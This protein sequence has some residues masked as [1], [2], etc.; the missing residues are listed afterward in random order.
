MALEAQ[1]IEIP[2]SGGLDTKS[3]EKLVIPGKLV[4][5]ENGVFTKRG[6]I[7]KRSGYVGLSRDIEGGGSI[8]TAD[9]LAVYDS[10][11]AEDELLQFGGRSVHGYSRNIGRWISKGRAVPCTVS[12]IEILRNSAQQSDVDS[13]TANGVTVFAWVDSRGGNRVCAIDE[14]SGSVLLAE[15]ALNSGGGAP[16]V[17]AI[18]PNVHVLY[19]ADSDTDVRRRTVNVGA[20]VTLGSESVLATDLDSTAP[21]LDVY[22]HGTKSVLVWASTAG[23]IALGYLLGNGSI[24]VALDGLPPQIII[25]HPSDTF[26]PGDVTPGTDII[27]LPAH[28]LT[29]NTVVQF[30]STGTLPAGLSLATD[31]WVLVQDAN[32]I[33]V[34]ASLGGGAVDITDAGT[35][36]HTI[37]PQEDAD[38]CVAVTVEQA[39]G[40]IHVGWHSD[41]NGLRVTILRDD[42]TYWALPLPMEAVTSPAAVNLTAVVVSLGNVSQWYWEVFDADSTKHLLKEATLTTQ[43]P[44]GVG[45]VAG[46]AVFKRSLGL[47]GKAFVEN[48]IVHVTGVHDSNLQATFFTLDED[49]NT[50]ARMLPLVAGGLRTA[51]TVAAVTAGAGSTHRVALAKKTRFVSEPDAA[52]QDTSFTLRGV[53]EGTL[54]FGTGKR[55]V[56]EQLGQNLHTAGGYLSAY[57]GQGYVEHGFF[58]FPEGVTTT[59]SASGGS[60][61]DG[62]YQYSAMYEWTDNAGQIHRSAPSV[63]VSAVVSGGGGSGSVTVTVPTLRITQKTSPRSE[64]SLAIYRT[65]DTGTLFQ[66]VTLISA[67]TYNDPTVD[68]VDFIDTITDTALASRELL[69]TTGGVLE[70]DAPPSISYLGRTKNRIFAVSEEDPNTVWF[71]K[72]YIPG[73]GVEFSEFQKIRVDPAGGPITAL[74]TMDDKVIIFKA[75]AIYGFGGTGPDEAGGGAAFPQPDEIAV[76]VGCADARAVTKSDN[77]L[78]FKSEKGRYRLNRSMNVEYVGAEVE[79][80]ND[81]ADTSAVLLADVNQIRFTTA[82]GPTLMYDYEHRQWGT[83]T[84]QAA[85]DAIR[86]GSSYVW[87][88]SDGKVWEETANIFRDGNVRYPIKL[89][90]AWIKLAGLQ[91]F[92]RVRR[93]L[94][95]GNANGEHILEVGVGYNY[96]PAYPEI[97]QFD[98]RVLEGSFWGSSTYWGADSVWGGVEDSLYQWEMHL[99]RQKSQS[100]RFRFQDLPVTAEDEGFEIAGLALLAGFKKGA[101]KLRNEKRG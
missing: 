31:Y 81:L 49:G 100:V 50:V 9:A 38:N 13:A 55:F 91:G 62:T 75:Q 11:S 26:V 22:Q 40:D 42:F 17:I 66:R 46:L 90:T 44:G 78:L 15:T 83:F 28:G 32:N 60:M 64:V 47:A 101:A 2:F 87:L 39:T 85:V 56:S 95:I 34:E 63:G 59:P 79:G 27:N 52:N 67:P 10:L 16:R 36:T 97:F 19:P 8:T 80:F 30:T 12:N 98:S 20:T 99:A 25:T 14:T 69:Y 96:E 43:D 51:G 77:G 33:K 35:G 37:T 61:A 58:L 70:N 72:E 89:V 94:A 88:G 93:A 7:K 84:G 41:L 48:L 65:A 23:G 21:Y 3:D 6:K 29:E 73:S 76:D 53:S 92:Q 82:T 45:V 86:W 68:T 18:P 1:L 54:D 4:E 74:A 5:M 71:S 57:D 24:A